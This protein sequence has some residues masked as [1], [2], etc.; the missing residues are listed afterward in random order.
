MKK[1]MKALL[2]VGVL[3]LLIPKPVSAGPSGGGPGQVAQAAVCKAL[4]A[5]EE[6]L[7][8]KLATDAINAL[9][10]RLDCVGETP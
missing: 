4:Q 7:L 3:G 6:K 5:L 10:D 9:K 8:P 2:I 1:L